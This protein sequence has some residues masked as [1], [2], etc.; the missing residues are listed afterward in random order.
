VGKAVP[1]SIKIRAEILL[2]KF[3]EK[4]GSDF[5]AN[6]RVI[7]ELQLPFSRFDRNKIAGFITKKMN[8]KKK[9]TQS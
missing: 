3:G 2:Q 8:E 5:E 1:K 9:A 4:F 6:K 7:N